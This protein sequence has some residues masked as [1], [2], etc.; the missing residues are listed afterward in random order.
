MPKSRGQTSVSHIS[1][2]HATISP[3]RMCHDVLCFN[4]ADLAWLTIVY[5]FQVS[6][7]RC[8]FLMSSNIFKKYPQNDHIDS[9]DSNKWTVAVKSKVPGHVDAQ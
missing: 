4:F 6:C 7:G 2:F 5:I 1:V 3:A 8:G 9:E